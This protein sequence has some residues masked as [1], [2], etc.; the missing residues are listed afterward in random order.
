MAKL[1]RTEIRSLAAEIRAELTTSKRRYIEESNK[2]IKD[3]NFLYILNNKINIVCNTAR[4]EN[5]YDILTE[6]INNSRYASFNVNQVSLIDFENWLIECIK[7]NIDRIIPDEPNDYMLE[8]KITVAN[9]SNFDPHIFKSQ[10]ISEYISECE[11]CIENLKNKI[12]E[13]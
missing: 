1:T 11:E 5:I 2:I 8:R 12:L 10:I 9:I 6:S 13:L 4:S 3:S 7:F